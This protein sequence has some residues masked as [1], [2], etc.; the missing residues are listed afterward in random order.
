MC[1]LFWFNYKIVN[2]TLKINI[3]IYFFF[4]FVTKE[5]HE[6][7]CDKKVGCGRRKD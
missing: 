7:S 3:W 6:N 5:M 4:F 2:T 1:R